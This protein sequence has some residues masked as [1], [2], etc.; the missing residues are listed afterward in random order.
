MSHT[1]HLAPRRY[2][3]H[4]HSEASCCKTSCTVMSRTSY[5]LLRRSNRRSGASWGATHR[6]CDGQARRPRPHARSATNLRECCVGCRVSFLVSLTCDAMVALIPCLPRLACLALP[7]ALRACSGPGD[8]LRGQRETGNFW[9][10]EPSA[11]QS[12]CILCRLKSQRIS[13]ATLRLCR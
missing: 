5:I 8:V 6:V 3:K 9:S 4:Y 12:P 10:C 13:R 1:C 2:D 7:W 11:S